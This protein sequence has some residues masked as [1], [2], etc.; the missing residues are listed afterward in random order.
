[1]KG[2]ALPGALGRRRRWHAFFCWSQRAL[3][4]AGLILLS[5]LAL[6]V[7][8][9]KL[10]DLRARQYLD[11]T[12]IQ[13]A[14]RQQ[15]SRP[16]ALSAVAAPSEGDILGRL[17]ISRL[18]VSVA[19]LQGTKPR[20]LRLGVGHVAGTALPGQSGNSAIAGH[21]DTFF[22]ALKEIRRNDEIQLRTATGL[23]RY[24][25]DWARVVSPGDVAV[26]APSNESLLT[27]VTCY[28]F[29]LVGAAPDRFVVRA[30]LN[31]LPIAK[32]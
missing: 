12:A 22:R 19:V 5:Y 21:R 18:G 30:H 25:V 2:S 20:T 16:D 9:A 28:P 27:L 15:A 1:M 6:V 14:A 31:R 23:S 32:E 8:Q 17:E 3:F 24:E 13:Q 7:L 29:Y 26:L 4:A 11:S 10:Y